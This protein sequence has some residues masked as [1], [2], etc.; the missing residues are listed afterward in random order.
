MPYFHKLEGNTGKFWSISLHGC[1]LDIRYGNIKV[2]DPRTST[3]T[4]ATPEKAQK[5]YDKLI[6]QKLEDGYSRPD[7][8]AAPTGIMQWTDELLAK[9]PVIR[10]LHVPPLPWQLTPFEPD[11]LHITLDGYKEQWI[12]KGKDIVIDLQ[13]L[14]DQIIAY[15]A[16]DK[17][18]IKREVWAN[19]KLLDAWPGHI[20]ESG[21]R[22]QPWLSPEGKKQLVQCQ[23]AFVQRALLLLSTLPTLELLFPYLQHLSRIAPF[24]L[25]NFKDVLDVLR[26]SIAHLDGEQHA[27]ALKLANRYYTTP[28]LDN[29]ACTVM[30]AYL[31][32]HEQNYSTTALQIWQNADFTKRRASL[33][34]PYNGYSPS[35]LA[36]EGY[37]QELMALAE[38]PQR[39]QAVAPFTLRLRPFP[40]ELLQLHISGYDCEFYRGADIT[41]NLDVMQQQIQQRIATEGDG[42]PSSNIDTPHE[43][44][45]VEL[46]R[47]S[48]HVEEDMPLLDRDGIQGLLTATQAIMERTI[49]MAGPIQATLN[50]LNQIR[51]HPNPKDVLSHLQTLAMLRQLIG[52]L[53]VAEYRQIVEGAKKIVHEHTNYSSGAATA[54]YLIFMTDRAW[55]NDLQQAIE[56]TDFP[57]LMLRSIQET[58]NNHHLRELA[59]LLA[60]CQLQ[61]DDY[62]WV[63][64]RQYKYGVPAMRVAL[65]AT[66]LGEGILPV[67]SHI[68]QRHTSNHSSRADYE[69]GKENRV[70][71]AATLINLLQSDEALKVILNE[72]NDEHTLDF[73]YV[74]ASRY[75]LY[76]K[77]FLESSQYGLNDHNHLHLRQF[78]EQIIA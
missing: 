74:L 71:A 53:P 50:W 20:K 56:K 24:E 42:F 18:S 52:S 54:I 57:G 62:I 5:E 33:Y 13:P 14:Q 72:G 11:M 4:L 66:C 41:L 37:F 69:R 77:G 36:Q 46:L 64:K 43:W 59:D 67:L 10:G 30:L 49:F 55:P 39:S 45:Y 3:K 76:L 60:Y 27:Q 75:P 73:L 68:L 16:G 63:V 38:L 65:W 40:E 22:R 31:F 28:D 12:Y 29:I 9:R 70:N 61:A 78:I 48:T 58:K 34:D 8:F 15:L 2:G 35:M 44:R 19:C 6:R 1:D 17:D 26:H 23:V 21:W 51:L 32:P 25:P 47:H 7:I